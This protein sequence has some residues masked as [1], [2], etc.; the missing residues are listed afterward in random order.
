MESTPNRESASSRG[1]EEANAIERKND[2]DNNMLIIGTSLCVHSSRRP[3]PGKIWMS[4]NQI[5]AIA[6]RAHVSRELCARALQASQ[7]I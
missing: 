7:G 4:A 2:R 1:P 3:I 5:R 6:D